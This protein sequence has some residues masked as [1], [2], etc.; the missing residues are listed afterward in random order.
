[1]LSKV[2]TSCNVGEPLLKGRLLFI[3]TCHLVLVLKKTFFLLFL[4][5]YSIIAHCSDCGCGLDGR[6]KSG[7]ACLA[8]LSLPG[9]SPTCNNH[10]KIC[11]FELPSVHF[12]EPNIRNCKLPS[13][14]FTICTHTTSLPFDLTS[15]QEK[16]PKKQK[17]L[18]HG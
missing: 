7:F 4:L 10:A 9:D 14:D 17:K 13:E 11:S 1:M 16:L 8:V 3:V 2:S 18:F 6:E 12:G 15:D 5:E